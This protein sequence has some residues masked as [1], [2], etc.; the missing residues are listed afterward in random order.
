[1]RWFILS[2]VLLIS[3]VLTFFWLSQPSQELPKDPGSKTTTIIAPQGSVQV[4]LA[5]TLEERRRGLSGRESLARD[6]G[7]LFVFDELVV[8]NFWMREMNFAIDI[9]WLDA[10]MRVVGVE[11]EV[12]PETFPETF[13]PEAPILYVLELAS[14]ESAKLGIDSGVTLLFESEI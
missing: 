2:S 14:G 8:P 12:G 4:E 6:S 3:L 5:L 1:M 11:R 9:V 13:S 10:S 7:M